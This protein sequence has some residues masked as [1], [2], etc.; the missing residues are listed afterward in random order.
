ML[1][2]D[3][4]GVNMIDSG[5]RESPP[6]HDGPRPPSAQ[7]S[8]RERTGRT[9]MAVVTA[10]Y[11]AAPAVR[12]PADVM[13][14]GATER[15]DRRPGPRA[16]NRQVDAS[17]VDSTAPMTTRLFDRAEQRDPQHLRRWIVLVDGNNHQIDRIRAEAH[18]HGVRINP[19]PR[20]RPRPGIRLESR[21]GPAPHPAQPSRFSSPVPPVTCSN[22][23][24]PGSSPT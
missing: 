4:T 12:G 24:Q 2:I 20:L 5:L 6:D 1:S 9:R 17:V 22:T 8:C 16:V 18:A 3:A 11:D 15:A 19:D 14:A 23:T 10:V 21:R 7:L 13:P